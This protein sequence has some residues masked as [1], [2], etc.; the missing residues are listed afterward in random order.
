M[1]QWARECSP[2][3]P[4]RVLY[5]Q[6]LEWCIPQLAS[7]GLHNHQ[8]GIWH[9]PKF[10]ELAL[11][12]WHAHKFL[13][14]LFQHS[15]RRS[16]ILHETMNATGKPKRAL[17]VC[18]LLLQTQIG[19]QEYV[20][21][22]NNQFKSQRSQ[23]ALNELPRP[24]HTVLQYQQYYQTTTKVAAYTY[25]LPCSSTVV[26]EWNIYKKNSWTD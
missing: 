10:L 16:T 7:A 12:K 8:A 25:S 19:S 5:N 9:A 6:S 4:W 20:R 1:V 23:R 2:S 26:F 21:A 15:R 13:A 24:S 3:P 18:S 14:A 22:G 11:A 17:S